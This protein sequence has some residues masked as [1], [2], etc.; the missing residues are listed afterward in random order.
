MRLL[1]LLLF[2]KSDSI[3]E[4]TGCAGRRGRI[5]PESPAGCGA[6][7]SDSAGA[8]LPPRQGSLAASRAGSMRVTIPL[9]WK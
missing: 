3:S 8:C 9:S 4:K 2:T 1:N 7:L 6:N 5:V